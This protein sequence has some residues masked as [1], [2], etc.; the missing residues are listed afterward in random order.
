MMS[1]DAPEAL[2][3]LASLITDCFIIFAEACI[4]AAG[5]I[6]HVTSTDFPYVWQPEGRKGHCSDDICAQFSPEFF[7]RFSKPYNNRIFERFG[8]GMMHNCGPNP[9][10]GEYLWHDP[11]IKAVDLAYD[12]SKND[13]PAFKEAFTGKGIIYFGLPADPGEYRRV[14]EL[15]AP[16]VIAIPQVSVSPGPGREGHLRGFSGGREGVRGDG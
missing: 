7:N 11:R 8:G 14:M 10:A 4:E 15:L 12:Y 1:Y 6:D 2:D 3:H 13:L 5:G 9:C 16:D